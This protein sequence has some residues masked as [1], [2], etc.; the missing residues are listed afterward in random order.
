MQKRGENNKNFVLPFFRSHKYHKIKKNFTF[1]LVKNK[2]CEFWPI[3]KELKNFLHKKLA[4][5]NIGLESEI[6]DPEK[7]IPDPG[8]GVKKAPDPG[9]G[10]ETLVNWN[11]KNVEL[12][13]FGSC[14]F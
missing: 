10:T 3:F 1:E 2:I 11:A 4:L 8:Y 9:S 13:F 12:G 5:K 6:R 7:P 14:N